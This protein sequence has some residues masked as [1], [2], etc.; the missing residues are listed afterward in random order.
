MHVGLLRKVPWV[1]CY[2]LFVAVV[3]QF[4]ICSLC[5]IVSA[6]S[7][8]LTTE[9]PDDLEIRV[10][11]GSR[12]LKVTPVNSSYVISYYSL[13]LPQAVSCPVYEI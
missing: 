2:L 1:S 8:L 5:S 11:D 3:F 13:V 6:I 4:L 9:N 12:S 10:M 7:V